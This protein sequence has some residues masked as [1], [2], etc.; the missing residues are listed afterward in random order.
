MKITLII[1]ALIGLG[2]I[3]WG[4]WLTNEAGQSADVRIGG[5]IPIFLGL[6]VWLIDGI[7]ALIYWLWR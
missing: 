6:A 4:Y 5:V 3:G 2:L 1:V 7:A